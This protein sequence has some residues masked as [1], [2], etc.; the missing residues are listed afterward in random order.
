MDDDF[1]DLSN[2]Q[3]QIGHSELRKGVAK[4]V[5]LCATVSALNSGITCTP[6][7]QRLSGET[8]DGLFGHYDLVL[9]ATDNPA[10]RYL[11]NDTCVRQGKPLVSGAALGT[12]GQ[13]SVYNYKGGPCYRCI[14][15]QPPTG[16]VSNCSDAGVLGP[17]TGVIGALQALEV[18]KIASDFAKQ[19]ESRIGRSYAGLGA[20]LA[21]R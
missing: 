19:S 1:V 11:I 5:S 13:L 10:T 16:S 6:H 17:I 4:A 8:V 2:L 3:R 21:G 14:H 15:K 18:L 20:P 9:D 7:I 12:D